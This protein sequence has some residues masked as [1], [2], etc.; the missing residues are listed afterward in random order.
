MSDP[1]KT[2]PNSDAEMEKTFDDVFSTTKKEKKGE[3]DAGSVATKN[4]LGAAAMAGAGVTTGEGR[5]A[6]KTD[7]DVE[8]ISD[9][10]EILALIR[11]GKLTRTQLVALKKKIVEQRAKIVAEKSR[12]AVDETLSD[13]E[14]QEA[15]AI[16]K[17]VAEEEENPRKGLLEKIKKHP[18]A[19]AVTSLFLCCTIAAS[20]FFIGHG[21]KKKNVNNNTENNTAYTQ[22]D[23]NLD[24]GSGDTVDLGGGYTAVFDETGNGGDAGGE[25][26]EEQKTDTEK[27][28]EE[29]LVELPNGLK[30]DPS[31]Y[32]GSMN[33]TRD[34]D[35]VEDMTE[36]YESKD[37][38][39][40]KKFAKK[41][42]R[43][44]PEWLAVFVHQL[45]KSE[46][47]DD[48]AQYTQTQLDTMLDANGGGELQDKM[49]GVA[50]K[51]TDAATIEFITA[52][53][54]ES[55]YNTYNRFGKDPKSSQVAKGDEKI[56]FEGGEKLIVMKS[57]KSTII[58]NA[59]CGNILVMIFEDDGSVT[60][61]EKKITPEKPKEET[62][63][64]KEN[65]PE[66]TPPNITPPNITP[67]NITPPNIT[68]PNITPPNITPPNITPPNITPPNITPPNIT[69]PNLNPK[70]EDTHAGSDV[71]KLD[72]TPA[73]PESGAKP[74]VA[75]EENHVRADETPGAE[76]T[77]DEM[78]DAGK[79]GVG[80]AI[81]NSDEVQDQKIQPEYKP[82][83][84]HQEENEVPVV[85]DGDTRTFEEVAPNVNEAAA[86]EN[87]P[88][89]AED[90]TRTQEELAN[91]FAELSGNKAN[92]TTNESTQ[93]DFTREALGLGNPI[94][95]SLSNDNGGNQ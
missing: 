70:G 57:E 53:A 84:L 14:R 73:Q 54:G 2:K 23:D 45:D 38:E 48:L 64:E 89:S 61:I 30:Y 87:T 29:G 74:V 88:G 1:E 27:E 68:P 34:W 76:V 62:P 9:K 59:S 10:E 71:D 3:S 24:S 11:S 28:L 16:K 40:V 37:S 18:K 80:E 21:I 47:G 66:V 91:R 86:A 25:S 51:F 4:K 90:G 7:A 31:Y 58:I 49:I 63:P 42:Y 5:G 93:E 95:H 65:P 83:T 46:Q 77:Q 72:E 78:S 60:I 12:A 85:G 75:T 52:K 41:T 13:K 26:T 32:D 22:Q 19:A 94:E 20:A 36:I 35:F 55:A 15:D 33:R 69:P 82:E 43:A 44:M 56:V 79:E 6:E 17:E 67:P 39:A 92:A 50:D 8:K 81:M